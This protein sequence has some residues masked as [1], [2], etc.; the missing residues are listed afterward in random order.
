MFE[1]LRAD[2]CVEAAILERNSQRGAENV[3]TSLPVYVDRHKTNCA[4]GNEFTIR[5]FSRTKIEHDSSLEVA[6]SS[7]PFNQRVAA[8]LRGILP[9]RRSVIFLVQVSDF[10]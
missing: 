3:R 2:N 1:R 8:N 5:F 4:A 10:S 7:E 9:G 6:H